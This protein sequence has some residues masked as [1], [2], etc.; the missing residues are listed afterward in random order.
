MTTKQEY[1]DA[2]GQMEE[3][4]YNFDNC[5]SAMNKFKK[6]VNLLT[7]LVNECFEEKTETNY[8]HFEDE[9]IKN[10]VWSLALVDGKPNQCSDV[11]CLDC[12]F[13]TGHGCIE[14]IKEWLKKPYEKQTYKLS[15]FEYDL[16]NAYDRCKEC[17]L[18]NEIEALKRMSEK[19][20]FKGIDP[21]TKVHEILDNCEV[22][23]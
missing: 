13:S 14:K 19:G 2:L 21:F 3:S 1:I 20:Y 9:I 23:K 4:Y 18:L 22:I 15:R 8:E 7:G 16:I 17:C 12:G 10:C 6:C 5:I 11:R